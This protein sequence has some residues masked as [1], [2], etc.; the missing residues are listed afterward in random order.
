MAAI[1]L[2]AAGPESSS[3]LGRRPR[4][5][6]QADP[7]GLDEDPG[8]HGE[9]HRLDSHGDGEGVSCGGADDRAEAHQR[10]PARHPPARLLTKQRPGG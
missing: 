6:A 4:K 8:R 3:R 7:G 10:Q 5:A 1:V 9:Q 2:A